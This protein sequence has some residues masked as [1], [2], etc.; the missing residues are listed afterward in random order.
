[1]KEWIRINL[2]SKNNLALKSK[3]TIAFTLTALVGT[4]VILFILSFLTTFSF[5]EIEVSVYV[6]I[7]VLFFSFIIQFVFDEVLLWPVSNYIYLRETE[8][9][10]SDELVR[11]AS[12][13]IIIFPLQ[14]SFLSF[15]LWMVVGLILVVSLKIVLEVQNV[16]LFYLYFSVFNGATVAFILLYYT[17]KLPFESIAKELFSNPTG[18]K[19]LKDIKKIPLRIKL[20]V[21]FFLI[22][23]S[24]IGFIILFSY[25]NDVELIRQEKVNLSSR[26]WQASDKVDLN[27]FLTTFKEIQSFVETSFTDFDMFLYDKEKRELIGN[28]IPYQSSLIDSLLI[29]NNQSI[30][31]V[32]FSNYIIHSFPQTDRYIGIIKFSVKEGS[33]KFFLLYTLLFSFLSLLISL[34]VLILFSSDFTRPISR[35]TE[36]VSYI[37]SGDF[38]KKIFIVSEDDSSFLAQILRL[39]TNSTIRVVSYLYKHIEQAKVIAEKNKVIINRINNKVTEIAKLNY[40]DNKLSLSDIKTVINKSDNRELLESIIEIINKNKSLSY[41]SIQEIKEILSFFVNVEYNVKDLE[42]VLLKKEEIFSDI[43][44]VITKMEKSL[45]QFINLLNIIGDKNKTIVKFN[46]EIHDIITIMMTNLAGQK[47]SFKGIRDNFAEIKDKM[48]ELKQ[49]IEE[50]KEIAL[51]IGVITENSDMISFNAAI[52][53]FSALTYSKEFILIADNLRDLTQRTL[54]VTGDVEKQIEWISYI[55]KEVFSK[56]ELLARNLSQEKDKI[57]SLHLYTTQIHDSTHVLKEKNSDYTFMFSDLEELSKNI[58]DSFWKSKKSIDAFLKINNQYKEYISKITSI[59][60]KLLDSGKEIND[61][62]A[63]LYEYYIGFEQKNEV[64]KATYREFRSIVEK[65]YLNFDQEENDEQ[66]MGQI[67]EEVNSNIKEFVKLNGK[68]ES[69]FASL[70]EIIKIFKW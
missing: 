19:I 56:I 30:K 68:N 60:Q 5:N 17:F 27:R 29:K 15:L 61:A 35:V 18:F 20:F 51:N 23:I 7:V 47:D 66:I 40:F 31:G 37:N 59:S 38:T 3:I 26:L 11:K 13:A 42:Q 62:S 69:Y 14:A 9:D 6:L 28:N 8:G 49:K 33:Y 39:F 44:K 63:I 58:E 16:K 43:E 24:I 46:S 57:N 45:E 22:L 53:A 54:L 25:S 36:V 10:I 34:V 50:A 48:Y 1:L 2:K 41:N 52:I 21:T 55:E 65:L 32:E 70:D 64:L 4:M 12:K 67:V